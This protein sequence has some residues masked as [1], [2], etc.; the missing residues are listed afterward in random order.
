ML[1]MTSPRSKGKKTKSLVIPYCW[2][3][4]LIICCL[5][6]KHNIHQRSESSFHLAEEEYRLGNLKFVP[7]GEEDEVFGMQIPKELITGN[8]RIAP[9]YNAYMEMVAK[10]ER[11]ITAEEG[12]KKKSAAKADQSK[13][14]A[15]SKKS[16]HAPAKQPKPMKEKSTKPSPVKKA[17]KGKVRKVRKGKSSLQ[18]VDEPDEEPQ[19]APKPQ[20]RITV[21]EEAPTG[22]SAQPKGDTS[23]NIVCDTPSPTDAET[24]AETDKTNSEG[25][26]EILNI[27]EE[28]GEDVANK[29]GPDLGQSHVALAGPNPEPMHEDFVATVYPKVHES[30]KHTYEEHV[31]LENLLSSTGTLSSM[32][33]LDYFNFGDQFFNDKPNKEEPDKANI[34]TEVKSIVTVLIHQASSSV[35]PLSTPVIDFTPPK[36]DKTVQALQA[37]LRECFRDLS[38]AKMKEILHQQMFESVTYHSQPEHV[39]LYEALKASIDRDNRDEFLEATA[40]FRGHNTAH[41]PKIKT[42]PDWL[43]IVPEKDIPKTPE[44]DWVIPSNDLPKAGNNWADALAKSHKD[45]EENKLQSKTRDIGLFIK[46]YCKRTGKKKLTKADLEGPAFMTIDLMNPEGHRVV[47]DVRKPLPLGGPPGQLNAA[48][49]LDFG[50]EELV[51]SLW[52]ESERDYDITAAYVRSNM[53]ILSDTSLKMYERYGYT[54]LREIVIRRAYY[55]EYKI[56]EADFKNLHPNDFEDLYL[57]HLQGKLNHLPG[58]DKVHLFNTVNMWIRNI[59]IRQCVADLQ[60]GIES[61]QTKLNLIQPSW[62]ALDFLFKED[63]TI[64]SKPMDVIYRDRSDQK[65][66]MRLNE[67]HKFSDGTLTRVL[68]RLDH[69]VKDFRQFKYNPGIETRIWSEDDKRR[70]KEFMEVIESDTYTGNPIKEI[71]LKLNLPDHRSV[72]TDPEVQ[73]KMEMEIPRSSGVNFITACS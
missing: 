35:P 73:V 50:L 72:L 67:V 22:P 30:L 37:P 39:A 6:R 3:T 10:H 28:Q 48:H 27:G 45:P 2:F 5:G 52:I 18:L 71:L 63:Y 43:K 23:A 16:K 17:D 31:H 64:I 57:L 21:T 7:K 51:P 60:L 54:Y 55:N 33:N 58:S 49:Y 59:V 14:P 11:K 8:I 42:R 69:M 29:V 62:D 44:P 56:S 70:C 53:R 9:Y 47:P 24:G 68:E 19:P 61:Y 38:E 46:W 25:D 20:R 26:T 65:K 32:K 40:K 36:P 41:L 13:K 15:T 34:E 66:M 12:G 4:K 1:T